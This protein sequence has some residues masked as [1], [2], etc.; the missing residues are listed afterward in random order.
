ML[1]P[2]ERFDRILFVIHTTDDA[3]DLTST[4]RC[5]VLVNGIDGMNFHSE[6]WINLDSDD[7]LF[8]MIYEHA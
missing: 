5:S 8:K 2:F 1:F 4:D 7:E 3:T 6:R